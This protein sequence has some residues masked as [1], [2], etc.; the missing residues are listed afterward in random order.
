VLAGDFNDWDTTFTDADGNTGTAQTL[1]ILKGSRFV[2][3]GQLLPLSNRSSSGVGLVGERIELSVA[4]V[5]LLIFFPDH[6]LLTSEL[7]SRVT[8]VSIDGSGY[9]TTSTGRIA[10]LYSDHLPLIVTLTD[11]ASVLSAQLLLCAALL[12]AFVSV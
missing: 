1:P 12:A 3:V 5:F 9:P 7:N 4:L 2:N 11:T 10:A 8:R 6:I